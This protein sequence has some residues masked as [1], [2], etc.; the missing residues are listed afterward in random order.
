MLRLTPDAIKHLRD[1][2]RI[3][4]KRVRGQVWFERESIEKFQK[5]FNRDDYLTKREMDKEI[6]P[7]VSFRGKEGWSVLIHPVDIH[8]SGIKLITGSDEIPDE[9]RVEFEEFGTTKYINKK[10][11]AKTI[12]WL[13][14]QYEEKYP[15]STMPPEV[16]WANRES[17]VKRS[18]FQ[19]RKGITGLKGRKIIKSATVD[20]TMVKIEKKDK[21]EKK[22]TRSSYDYEPVK[23]HKSGWSPMK[24]LLQFKVGYFQR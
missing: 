8:V 11:L 21:T 20:G 16:D 13:E 5:E 19:L 23:P 2:K 14:K 18:G 4:W 22:R 15:K 12:K 6:E 17:D 1:S 10:S 24:R 3:E 7:Y 9:Y